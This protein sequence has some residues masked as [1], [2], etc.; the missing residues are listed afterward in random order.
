VRLKTHTHDPVPYLLYCSTERGSGGEYDER[1][2][3]FEPIVPG[4]ELMRRLVHTV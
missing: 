2:A 1:G 3:A 4:H